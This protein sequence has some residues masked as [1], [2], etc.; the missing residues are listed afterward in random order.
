MTKP[1]KK[2]PMSPAARVL[3][4]RAF[5]AISAVEGLVL[6]PKSRNRLAAMR[7]AKLSPGEQRA[8]IIRAYTGAKSRG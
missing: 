4:D 5:A 1:S 2:R 8:A 6:S 7:R 3:G